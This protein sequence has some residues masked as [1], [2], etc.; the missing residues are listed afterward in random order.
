MPWCHTGR[1]WA[2]AGRPGLTGRAGLKRHRAKARPRGGDG[3]KWSR[4]HAA[5]P[6]RET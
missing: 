5:R 1:V 4:W 6:T 2:R 3:R